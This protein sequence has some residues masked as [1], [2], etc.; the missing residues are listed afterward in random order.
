MT[1]YLNIYTKSF[2]EGQSWGNGGSLAGSAGFGSKVLG[3]FEKVGGG[4]ALLS[5]CWEKVLALFPSCILV[6]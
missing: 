5:M 6:S 4:A 3:D 2:K 1:T